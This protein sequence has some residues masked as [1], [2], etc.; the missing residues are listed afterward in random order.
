M[1]D[2]KVLTNKEKK[3][4][5]IF[6]LVTFA[7]TIIM[8]LF[9]SKCYDKNNNATIFS[10]IQAFFPMAGVAAVILHNTKKM[11]FKVKNYLI[12]YLVTTG[13]MLTC[14][15]GT[16]LLPYTLCTKISNIV[17]Q[18]GS[19]FL[20]FIVLYSEN[21][22][23]HI[24]LSLKKS[25]QKE[26][27]CYTF[28]FVIL[29][30]TSLFLEYFMGRIFKIDNSDYLLQF[31]LDKNIVETILAILLGPLNFLFTSIAFLG[32]EYGWRRFLQ[33]LLQKKF[34]LRKGILILGF[35]WGIWHLPLSVYVYSNKNWYIQ[36]IGQI[37][38]C[39]AIGSFLAYVY[40]KTKNIWICTWLHFCNNY[41]ASM[42]A[43]Y[44]M[45]RPETLKSEIVS[46]IACMICFLPFLK[47][48]V[49]Q[50]K[51]ILDDMYL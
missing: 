51:E 23:D 19:I 7:L 30:F 48:K 12:L 3:D 24:K 50:D 25:S 26:W 15:V 49:F 34:G 43:A 32:E 45:N 16:L 33:P 38:F 44:S 42:L 4:L 46:S 14:G 1:K 9:I 47:S 39:I 28:L 29:Y 2:N 22:D 13:I 8:S 35:I 6:I 11:K 27:I 21:T 36:L 37:L 17:I 18:I 41:L 40:L 20:L 5:A 31:F 10:N